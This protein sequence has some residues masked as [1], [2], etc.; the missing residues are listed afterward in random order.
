MQSFPKMLYQT[1]L[2]CVDRSQ[3]H[4]KTLARTADS[5]DCWIVNIS[6]AMAAKL[7]KMPRRKLPPRER[8]CVRR[9][10]SI[11][12]CNNRLT[13][14][15]VVCCNIFGKLCTPLSLYVAKLLLGAL[16]VFLKTSSYLIL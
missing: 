10:T 13:Q 11:E 1:T 14:P 9:A 4:N 15:E 5:S 8:H 12:C 16:T 7:A 6:A 3:Q 2:E